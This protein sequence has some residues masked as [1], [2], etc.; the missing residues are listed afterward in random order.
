MVNWEQ[1]VKPNFG[2]HDAGQIGEFAAALVETH[3]LF[4]NVDFVFV[5]V[6]DVEPLLVDVPENQRML[7]AQGVCGI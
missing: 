7:F 4:L 2:Y 1:E 5:Q 6:L 3:F